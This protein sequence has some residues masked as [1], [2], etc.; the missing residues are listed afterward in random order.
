VSALPQSI[1]PASIFGPARC[2]ARDVLARTEP[3]D[4]LEALLRAGS[5]LATGGWLGV[6]SS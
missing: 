2:N 1:Y 5:A 6:A 3:T 4:D